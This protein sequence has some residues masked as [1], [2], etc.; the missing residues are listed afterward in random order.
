MIARGA[1]ILDWWCCSR[2]TVHD[3]T[4]HD[5]TVHGGT[6]HENCFWVFGFVARVRARAD[7]VF[8]GKVNNKIN[9]RE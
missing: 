8:K 6:I 3:G 1:S 2:V 5:G 4:V 9:S 7:N